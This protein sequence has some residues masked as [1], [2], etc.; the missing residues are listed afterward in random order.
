MSTA[1][2]PSQTLEQEAAM[3][4]AASAARAQ[5]RN[6]PAWLVLL[7]VIVLLSGAAFAW[8]G[9]SAH[10]EQRARARRAKAEADRVL[11]AAAKLKAMDDAEASGDGPRV[12]ETGNVLSRIE[13]A[14]SR[15]G[16]SKPVGVG[17]RNV[18][19]RRELKLNQVRI[20]YNVK[21]ESLGALLAWAEEAVRDVP[22]LEVYSLNV[23]P[24]A[25]EWSVNI[26]FSRWE[27]MEGS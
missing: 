25:S 8:S 21:D 3:T 17:T 11:A 7:G 16:L 14:G 4:L 12:V 27:R 1:A 26:V 20:S 13:A 9:W 2:T 6:R 15:V 10:G 18:T 5:R 24:E 19:A 22:G 23:R